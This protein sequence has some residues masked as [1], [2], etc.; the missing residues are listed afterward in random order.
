MI[1]NCTE[2]DVSQY[3]GCKNPIVYIPLYRPHE[4]ECYLWSWRNA[5]LCSILICTN[6]TSW[7]LT[8]MTRSIP[9]SL[10][11]ELR[12]IRNKSVISVICPNI[13]RDII[14]NGLG[15]DRTICWIVFDYN[16]TFSSSALSGPVESSD[17][18][19]LSSLTRARP[20]K[21]SNWTEFHAELQIT[22][23]SQVPLG[24][25]VNFNLRWTSWIF[26]LTSYILHIAAIH[27]AVFVQA[28]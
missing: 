12:L 22:P 26:H 7:S 6:I 2:G 9:A 25:N 10:V 14:V 3:W 13:T 16:T 18:R 27:I 4:T 17:Y 20:F 28:N 23:T 24:K 8:P 11:M 15:K 19:V 1:L 5:W 21:F